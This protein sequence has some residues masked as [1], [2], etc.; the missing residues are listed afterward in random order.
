MEMAPSGRIPDFMMSSAILWV[1]QA[2]G[3]AGFTTMGTPASKAGAAFSHRPQA[4]KLKALMKMAAPFA[5]S[6]KCWAE[7]TF[8]FESGRAGASFKGLSSPSGLAIFAKNF[9]V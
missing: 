8:V 7:K 6:R 2:V 1:S 9:T 4:G 3:D 5:G